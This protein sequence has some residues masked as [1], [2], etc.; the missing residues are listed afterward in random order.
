M[1]YCLEKYKFDNESG[2]RRGRS[3][4][5][6]LVDLDSRMDNV[7]RNQLVAIFFDIEKDYSMSTRIPP[8]RGEGENVFYLPIYLHLPKKKRYSH[9]ILSLKCK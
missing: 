2:F 4:L 3:T 7:K 1:L 8:K 9:K 5:D 6:N